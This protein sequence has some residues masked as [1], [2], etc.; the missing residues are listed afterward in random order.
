[1][2]QG[3]DLGQTSVVMEV[4]EMV[5]DAFSPNELSLETSKKKRYAAFIYMCNNMSEYMFMEV[6]NTENDVG[7]T[8]IIIVTIIVTPSPQYK[9]VYF[10][11]ILGA[12]P[13]SAKC[14]ETCIMHV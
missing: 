13:N 11:L 14:P 8:I 6:N 7:F 10:L 12:T 3:L 2:P 1:M 9:F 5:T 4:F